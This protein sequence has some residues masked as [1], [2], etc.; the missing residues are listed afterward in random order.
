MFFVASLVG[1]GQ[2]PADVK[3]AGDEKV[4]VYTTDAV[5]VQGATVNDKDGKAL[6]PQPELKWSVSDE[7]VAKLE[8]DKLTPVKSG[9]TQV[10]AC[11][12]D[13]VCKEYSFVVALPEKVVLS[14]ADGVSWAVGST[15]TLTAKVMSGEIEVPGQTVTWTSDNPAIATVDNAGLVTAVAAGT[16]KITATAGALTADLPLTIVAATTPPTN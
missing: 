6:D 11:A 5:Q 3:F 4:T 13:T 9:A 7:S 14:G 2:V 16:A 10:K 12:T 1:C 8:G 15:A